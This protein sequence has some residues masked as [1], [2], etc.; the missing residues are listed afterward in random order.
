MNETEQWGSDNNAIHVM[1]PCDK[2]GLETVA[3]VN[4]TTSIAKATCTCGEV[5]KFRY[6]GG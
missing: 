1:L 2:C 3:Q 4:R 5:L 6:K